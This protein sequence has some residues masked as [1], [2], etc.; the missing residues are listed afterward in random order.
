M[1]YDSSCYSQTLSKVLSLSMAGV[2]NVVGIKRALGVH[3]GQPINKEV[4]SGDDKRKHG[5]GVSI[6]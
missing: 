3:M 5:A 6:P 2:S 1:W 4:R